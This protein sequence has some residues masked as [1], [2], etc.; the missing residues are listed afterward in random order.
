MR[1]LA[2][3]A[4]MFVLAAIAGSTGAGQSRGDS[5]WTA[6]PD[7]AAKPNPLAGRPETVAGGRKLFHERCAMCHG[8]DGRG[9]RRGPDLTADVQAQ[10]DGELFWKIGSGN[11]R[12]GMP[13]FSYLPPPER[14]QLVLFLR[15]LRRSP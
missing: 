11:T 13:S 1:R 3:V 7:A 12:S 2:W 4:S 15:G 8:E 6:P 5:Q 10:T 14:W 9:T